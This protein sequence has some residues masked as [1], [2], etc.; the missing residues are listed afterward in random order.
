MKKKGFRVVLTLV[1]LVG[2]LWLLQRLLMPK[3]VTGV[4]E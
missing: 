3:Y 1:I 2:S 4:V